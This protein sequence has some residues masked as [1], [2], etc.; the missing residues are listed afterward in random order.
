MLSLVRPD[1]IAKVHRAYL[2]AGADIIET[3]TFRSTSIAQ[4]D[5]NLSELAYGVSVTDGC[6]DWA[7][8]ERTLRETADKLR[9][10]LP[11]RQQG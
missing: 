11:A 5:Y 7:T 10:V 3:N 8:T 2:D 1:I 6:I 4:A 9:E